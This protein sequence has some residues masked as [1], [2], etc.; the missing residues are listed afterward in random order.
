MHRYM[1]ASR[2]T[3]KINMQDIFVLAGI[4]YKFGFRFSHAAR[5][6]ICGS[7]FFGGDR[8]RAAAAAAMQPAA[9]LDVFCGAPTTGQIK[10][11][12]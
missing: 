7:T 10:S 2:K 4:R 9:K 1:H 8:D 11:S 12:T 6:H 3:A 5:G